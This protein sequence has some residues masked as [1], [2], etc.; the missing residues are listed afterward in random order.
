VRNRFRPGGFF[1]YPQHL[2]GYCRKTSAIPQPSRVG[3]VKHSLITSR[4]R[5]LCRYC[6]ATQIME[7]ITELAKL[8]PTAS[9]LPDYCQFCHSSKMELGKSGRAAMGVSKVRILCVGEKCKERR[10]CFSFIRVRRL[11]TQGGRNRLSD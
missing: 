10:S 1:L 7:I 2:L 5:T 6:Q 9:C 11:S 3:K 8:P 4:L